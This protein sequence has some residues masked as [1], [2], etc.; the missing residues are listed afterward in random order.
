MNGPSVDVEQSI[1]IEYLQSDSAKTMQKVDETLKEIK[2]LKEDQLRS[3]GADQ[4]IQNQLNSLD[5][6]V[7]ELKNRVDKM[8]TRIQSLEDTTS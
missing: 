6:D 3:E 8:G 7:S 1:R 5:K 4:V 2:T